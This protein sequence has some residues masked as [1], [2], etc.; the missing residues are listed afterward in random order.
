MKPCLSL[1]ETPLW[2][3]PLVHTV[4]LHQEVFSKSTGKF[5]SSELTA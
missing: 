2:S 4:L 3:V 5:G 1:M